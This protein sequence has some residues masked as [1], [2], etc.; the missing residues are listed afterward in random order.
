MPRKV[1]KILL[2]TIISFYFASLHADD[3]FNPQLNL[4]PGESYLRKADN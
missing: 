4:Q 2:I 1:S 3:S